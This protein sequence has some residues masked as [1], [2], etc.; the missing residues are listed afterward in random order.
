MNVSLLIL[1][2]MVGAAFYH[3]LFTFLEVF[4]PSKPIRK[5]T[6]R[7]HPRTAL[8][9]EANHTKARMYQ[10]AMTYRKEVKR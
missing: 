5:V 1:S 10:T 9:V 2:I 4:T 3:A 6:P 7:L 8:A